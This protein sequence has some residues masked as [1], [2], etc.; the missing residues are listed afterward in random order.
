MLEEQRA[1]I[2]KLIKRL[3]NEDWNRWWEEEMQSMNS[4]KIQSNDVF[5]KNLLEKIKHEIDKLKDV[6]SNDQT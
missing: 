5:Y 4:L 1:F 6:D 3:G 2:A